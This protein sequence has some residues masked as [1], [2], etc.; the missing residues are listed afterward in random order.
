KPMASYPRPYVT[1]LGYQPSGYMPH[2]CDYS[3]YEA[4]RDKFLQ[5]PQAWAT[6]LKGGIIWHLSWDAV[7]VEAA[8]G[9]PSLQVF[10]TGHHFFSEQA[11]LWDDEL[12]EDELN[13]ICSIY[14]VFTGSG[15]QDSH[16][17]W[18]P[19]PNAWEK[20]SLNIGQ[21]TDKCETWF[22]ICLEKIQSGDAQPKNGQE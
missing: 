12:S 7:G 18:W 2:D 4:L 15:K 19:K 14:K 11:Y 1:M 5:T 6:L 17:S 8:L 9:S 21:W 10:Q 16:Q 20:C 22:Q 13:L 3:S